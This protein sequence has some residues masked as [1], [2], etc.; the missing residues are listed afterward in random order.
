MNTVENILKMNAPF[1]I[2]EPPDYDERKAAHLARIAKARSLFLFPVPANADQIL[3]DMESHAPYDATKID[4]M[5]RAK[6]ASFPARHRL[7]MASVMH[8]EHPAWTATLAKLRKILLR[9]E[10]CIV[11]LLGP[12]GT[13]KTQLAVAVARYLAE[14]AIVGH[15]LLRTRE[16]AAYESLPD[17]LALVRGTFDGGRRGE[18]E[19][20]I[21]AELSRVR[22]LIVDECHEACGSEWAS[23]FFTRLVDRRYR[24]S[25][26]TVLISNEEPTAFAHSIGSSVADRLRECGAVVECCWPSFRISGGTGS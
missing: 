25:L 16:P 21:V 20:A 1:L 12:R 3:A 4:D 13:G 7:N 8:S 19:A 24:E 11:G 15:P 23:S 5:L 18:T 6:L 26:D 17:L 9:S 10:G 2:C 22:L 14:Q